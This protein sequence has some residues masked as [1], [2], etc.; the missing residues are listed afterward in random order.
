MFL[1]IAIVQGLLVLAHALV[2]ETVNYFWGKPRIPHLIELFI[3]LSI[4]FVPASLLVWRYTHF[5]AWGFYRLAAIWLGCLSF[6]FW[7]SVLCW[8]LYAAI[9]IY[10]LVG[11]LPHV[12]CYGRQ[13]LIIMFGIA[14]ACSVAAWL[15]GS[16]LRVTRIDVNLPGLPQAWKNR[17]AA[18]V[19]DLHLGPVR[20]YCFAKRVV[21]R[22]EALNPDLVF[23]TGDFYDGTAIDEKR[24]ASAWKAFPCKHGVFYV[25]GNHEEFSDRRKYLDAIREAGIRILNNEHVNIEGVQIA[26]VLYGEASE[27]DTMRSTL[28][29]MHLDVQ[30]PTI[31][32]SH[33]P[34]YLDVAEEAGV[35]LQLSGHTH[36]GQ[37]LP[38]SWVAVRVHG[39]FV[40]GLNQ[41]K[42]MLVYTSSGTGTWGPPMRLGTRSEI[43]LLRFV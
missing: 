27:R 18:L 15:N 36:K 11:P 41:F 29:Q 20:G 35:S 2:F 12:G 4:S 23:L 43:V 1:F 32:L 16:W 34:Q 13:L 19:S 39:K 42:R 37:V 38:W 6:F 28:A 30:K 31:L 5:F 9:Q 14:A 8:A 40:Y 22:V 3:V 24:I 21:N 33:V 10:G 26:G 17:K 7:A 25:T